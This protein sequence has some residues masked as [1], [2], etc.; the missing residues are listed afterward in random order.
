[1]NRSDNWFWS[2]EENKESNDKKKMNKEKRIKLKGKVSQIIEI[3]V[4]WC[5]ASKWLN[6]YD[7]SGKA[8]KSRVDY[9]KHRCHNNILDKMSI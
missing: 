2:L 4:P 9:S 8:L 1:M 7:Q 3:N 6:Y 5:H